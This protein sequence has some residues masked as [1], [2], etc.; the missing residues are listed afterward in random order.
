MHVNFAQRALLAADC[1]VGTV[2]W[3]TSNS[4]ANAYVISQS[5]VEGG[6]VPKWQSVNLVVSSGPPQTYPNTS[7]PTVPT[8]P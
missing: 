2:T 1:A 8:L 4:V 6:P 3:V 5:P 7:N